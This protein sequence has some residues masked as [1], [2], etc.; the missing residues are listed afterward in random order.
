MLR[1]PYDKNG[2]TRERAL[3]MLTMLLDETVTNWD[4]LTEWEQKFIED[5]M[6]RTHALKELSE[7]QLEKLEQIYKAR[8]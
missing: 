8:Q 3:W 1:R 2:T 4:T 7:L 5:M 6:E